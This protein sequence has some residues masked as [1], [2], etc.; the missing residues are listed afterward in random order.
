M[1]GGGEVDG[2]VGLLAVFEHGDQAAADGE[3]GPV[4]GVDVAFDLAV[5]AFNMGND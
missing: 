3:A 5:L 4:E 1:K 2:A